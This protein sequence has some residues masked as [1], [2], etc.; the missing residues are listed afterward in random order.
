MNIMYVSTEFKCDE[1]DIE[2]KG[3]M[4]F[5]RLTAFLTAYESSIATKCILHLNSN[6]SFPHR[7]AQGYYRMWRWWLIAWMIDLNIVW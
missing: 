1:E 3:V 5:G 7:F 4:I 6:T 2:I